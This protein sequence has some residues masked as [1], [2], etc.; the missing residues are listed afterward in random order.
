MRI[1]SGKE[2]EWFTMGCRL[3]A[4]RRPQ[5]DGLTATSPAHRTA[6]VPHGPHSFRVNV[7]PLNNGVRECPCFPLV[8]LCSK[9]LF[10]SRHQLSLGL[11]ARIMQEFLTPKNVIHLYVGA[12][13]QISQSKLECL[14]KVPP[15]STCFS[16]RAVVPNSQKSA[17]HSAW[18]WIITDGFTSVFNSRTVKPLV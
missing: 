18:I 16:S 1:S 8:P 3:V 5:C 10:M 2:P 9:G 13:S 11:T 14:T 6:I 7:V 4:R 15:Q 17:D 12:I